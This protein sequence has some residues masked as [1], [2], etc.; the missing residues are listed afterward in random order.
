MIRKYLMKYVIF[1]AILVLCLGAAWYFTERTDKVHEDAVLAHQEG[2][3]ERMEE[4][5][6]WAK[7]YI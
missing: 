4:D 2:F 7:Y 6:S 1:I 3:P 5:A